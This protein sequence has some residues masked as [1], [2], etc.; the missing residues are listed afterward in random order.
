MTYATDVRSPISLS[1]QGIGFDIGANLIS[2]GA[3]HG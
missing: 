2:D 1:L 3:Q